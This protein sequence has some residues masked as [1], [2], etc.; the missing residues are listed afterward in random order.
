VVMVS[1]VVS[2]CTICIAQANSEVGQEGKE[3]DT[4]QPSEQEAGKVTSA[5]TVKHSQV[6]TLIYVCVNTDWPCS[7]SKGCL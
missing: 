3:I 5:A 1:H 7:V 4:T 6:Y 2:T